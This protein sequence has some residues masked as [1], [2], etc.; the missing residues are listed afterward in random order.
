MDNCLT[1]EAL[2]MHPHGASLQHIGSLH[3]ALIKKQSRK[4]MWIAI[5]N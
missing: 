4:W 5:I 1:E 3:V 2:G